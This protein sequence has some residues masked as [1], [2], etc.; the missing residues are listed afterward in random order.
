VELNSHKTFEE[1]VA[2]SDILISKYGLNVPVVYDT[3]DDTFDKNYAVWPERYYIIK[4]TEA[5]PV[6][7]WIF[8]PNVEV[9]YDRQKNRRYIDVDP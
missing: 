6:L 5:E 7:D 9:G 8:Y 1:R 2:A 4:Q 3:M